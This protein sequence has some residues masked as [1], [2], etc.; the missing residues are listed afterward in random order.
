MLHCSHKCSHKESFPAIISSSV[1]INRLKKKKQG[2]NST[3][4]KCDEQKELLRR[5]GSLNSVLLRH[6]SCE[7][8]G[9]VRVEPCRTL[10][11]TSE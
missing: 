9:K 8:T 2:D 3:K 6:E 11:G 7:K 10:C 5:R 1:L 4:I